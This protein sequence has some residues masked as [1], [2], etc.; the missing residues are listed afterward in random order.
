MKHLTISLSILLLGLSVQAKKLSPS[1]ALGRLRNENIRRATSVI[2]Q[3]PVYTESGRTGASAYVFDNESGFTIV[4]ADDCAIPMLGYAETGK[5]DKENIPCGLQCWLEAYSRQIDFARTNS[6]PKYN[7]SA[8]SGNDRNPIAP[9]LSTKWGQG[10]PYNNLCPET[11]GQ[12]SVT[13]CVATA[14]AQVLNIYRHPVVGTNTH[15][16]SWNYFEDDMLID[17]ELSLDFSSLRFDWESMLDDYSGEYTDEE[18]NAVATLMYACGVAVDM[19]Y[20]TAYSGAVAGFVPYALS[21][22]FGYNPGARYVERD[23]WREDD[24]SWDDLVYDQI[25]EHGAVLYCGVTE[26]N[27]GHAFVCDGY[28]GDGFFHF[29]WGWNGVSDGWFRLDALAPQVQGTGGSAHSY[30]FNL[31]QNILAYL[32]HEGDGGYYLP[33]I[34]GNSDKFAVT[35]KSVPLGG[36]FTVTGTILNQSQFDYELEF[37]CMLTNS[38]TGTDGEVIKVYD[39]KLPSCSEEK[40]YKKAV[41]PDIMTD[42]VYCMRPVITW[43]GLGYWWTLPWNVSQDCGLR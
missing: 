3:T 9:A 18:A 1:Q 11:G 8:D 10:A 22:Y 14:M 36:K 29:N 17:G 39:L 42:G 12:R 33:A 26:A 4:S 16:Y 31:H 15:S 2:E 30:A 13:G 32:D 38:V 34:S 35:N 20:G 37:G 23:C 28:D 27:E 41:M 7:A 40:I 19:G 43:E 25:H 6:V 5:F 21:N 24:M